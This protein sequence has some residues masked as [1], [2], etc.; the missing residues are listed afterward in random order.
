MGDYAVTGDTLTDARLET[1]GDSIDVPAVID[2]DEN[3]GELHVQPDPVLSGNDH[4]FDLS[5]VEGLYEMPVN[6]NVA[7]TVHLENYDPENAVH[8]RNGDAIAVSGDARDGEVLT[9]ND[10][11]R[12]V[13]MA[14]TDGNG[15]RESVEIT[16]DAGWTDR[17][18]N[19]LNR[20]RRSRGSRRSATHS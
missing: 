7:V 12:H 18:W 1:D 6:S 19:R 8:W 4:E 2:P 9:R 5:I 14:Y 3:L 17:V 16:E 13:L 11:E 15:E 20:Y 10:G